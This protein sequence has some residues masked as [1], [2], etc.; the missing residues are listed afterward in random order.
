[1]NLCSLSSRCQEH[2][3]RDLSIETFKHIIDR[4]EFVDVN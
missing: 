3:K 1:M 4:R 2:P